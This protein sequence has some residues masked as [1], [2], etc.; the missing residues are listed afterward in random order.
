MR[1]AEIVEARHS[2]SPATQRNDSEALLQADRKS[3]LKLLNTRRN[4]PPHSHHDCL[5]SAALFHT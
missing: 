4:L 5:P 2:Q 1:L 3:Y